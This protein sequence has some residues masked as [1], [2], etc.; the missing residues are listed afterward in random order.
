MAKGKKSR[1]AGRRRRANHNAAAA[2]AP[3]AAN[4]NNNIPSRGRRW[5]SA[6]RA[7]R[8]TGVCLHFLAGRCTYGASCRFAHGEVSVLAPAS[9]VTSPAVAA[10][11]PQCKPIRSKGKHERH[12]GKGAS[13]RKGTPASAAAPVT[14]S[15]LFLLGCLCDDNLCEILAFLSVPDLGRA[16][17]TCAK[18]HLLQSTTAE[19]G[20]GGALWHQCFA[21]RFYLPSPR[22]SATLEL[23][24]RPVMAEALCKPTAYS[25]RSQTDWKDMVRVRSEE[26]QRWRREAGFD[27]AVHGNERQ[28]LRVGVGEEFATLSAAVQVASAYD[29][30]VV[31]PGDYTDETVR[32]AKTLEVLGAMPSAPAATTTV[33]KR[34]DED[35][36]GSSA[37]SGHSRY[38]ASPVS[39][40]AAAS[41]AGLVR[42][43][44]LDPTEFATTTCEMTFP[45]LLGKVSV[46]P[47]AKVRFSRLAFGGDDSVFTFPA[48]SR[49]ERRR[50][51]VRKTW[52]QY[53]ECSFLNSMFVFEAKPPAL[54][55]GF[56][57]CIL[58]A[59]DTVRT[60]EPGPGGAPGHAVLRPFSPD[61]DLDDEE[62]PTGRLATFCNSFLT[63]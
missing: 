38:L 62:S 58:V 56:A 27:H 39:V 40:V 57:R 51:G 30:I 47:G 29:R 33:A 46:A 32:V 9:D 26:E 19:N 44:P 41:P 61:D 12:K 1:G 15:P 37:F 52:V 50:R 42:A 60:A 43:D 24:G 35:S 45:A 18:W 4:N 48:P 14:P 17:A 34:P 21:R 7:Q 49:D 22:W 28:T 31:G 16:A 2:A 8:K 54:Q 25:A 11:S 10:A 6:S 63:E 5:Q 59:C 53:D 23:A 20:R 55:V 36:D 13:C 3:A